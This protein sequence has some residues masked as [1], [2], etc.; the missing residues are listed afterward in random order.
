MS[1]LFQ[2]L[3]LQSVELVCR[4]QTSV[5]LQCYSLTV[6][7][8]TAVG[9][10]ILLLWSLFYS[11]FWGVLQPK[12]K[13]WKKGINKQRAF[14]LL[15]PRHQMMSTFLA[16]LTLKTLQPY[17]VQRWL[18]PQGLTDKSV[19][20]FCL[21]LCRGQW[22]WVLLWGLPDC[23]SCTPALW[24]Q[25]SRPV[26]GHGVPWADGAGSSSALLLPLYHQ[27]AEH[28][29]AFSSR[30]PEHFVCCSLLSFFL[31]IPPSLK[32]KELDLKALD[33]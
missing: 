10:F 27:R 21:C 1:L 3:F 26:H 28:N 29:T 23:S 15:P 18:G 33:G 13:V 22:I 32:K 24:H 9:T 12:F 8:V 19:V 16:F 2:Y 31:F 30:V 6:S 4:R 5:L 20:F 14:S 11:I 25:Y 17:R 7:F